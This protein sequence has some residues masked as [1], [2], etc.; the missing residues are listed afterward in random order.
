MR[1]VYWAMTVPRATPAKPRGVC[2]PR[3]MLM[4]R[5]TTLTVMSTAIGKTVFCMP[6]NQP[7]NT[8]SERVAGASHILMKKYFRASSWTSAEQSMKR[9]AA[10]T[11]SHWISIRNEAESRAVASPWTK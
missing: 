11:K 3:K 10:S 2:R 1:P 7:L 4:P 5:L 6:M 9:K 8:I